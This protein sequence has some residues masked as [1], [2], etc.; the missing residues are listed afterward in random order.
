M[1]RVY[2]S[3]L[4]QPCRQFT[5]GLRTRQC[6]P[7]LR[8]AAGTVVRSGQSLPVEV[9]VRHPQSQTL[10]DPQATAVQKLSDQPVHSAHE[11]QDSGRLVT[12]K[13]HRHADA[14]G[15]TRRIDAIA[16][17]FLEHVLVEEDQGIHRLVLRNV[18]LPREVREK[19]LDLLLTVTQTFAEPHAVG[20]DTSLH[21]VTVATLSVD[22]VVTSP[23]DITHLIQQS[24]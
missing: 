19:S 11:R 4:W 3:S 20:A 12:G 5:G 9:E 17:R 18:A 22:R 23:H 15:R 8:H 1:A 14:C 7:E 24:G 13:D 2:T 10:G 21:P 6:L 16:R